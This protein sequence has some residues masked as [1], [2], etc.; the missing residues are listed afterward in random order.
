MSEELHKTDEITEQETKQPEV[1]V[2]GLIARLEKLEGSNSRL[3]EE[4]KT[5]KSKYRNLATDVEA[6]E[7]A[8]LEKNENWQDLLEIEKNK[9]SEMEVKLK[10]TKKSVLQKELGF[11][12]ASYAKDAHDVNDII[13]SL[14]K[15]LLT[16]D[17]ESLVVT[18]V[19]E[20]VNHVRE[21]KPWLFMKESKSGMASARPNGQP[22]K[23]TYEN[24]SVEEKDA[25]FADALT[26]LIT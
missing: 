13:S 23:K 21:S 6:K 9:R 3:L 19:S 25:L 4:S 20:A 15:D 22:E 16:I 24:S 11:K 1:D 26:Q 18:G 5:W 2:E 14:P 7:K 8:V 17:E 12:V 10:D